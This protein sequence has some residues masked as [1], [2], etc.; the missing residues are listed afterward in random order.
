[1]IS[2]DKERVTISI[3]KDTLKWLDRTAKRMKMNRSEMIEFSLEGSQQELKLLD[4]LGLKPER[5]TKVVHTIKAATEILPDLE[6]V[7][8][9]KGA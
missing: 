2:K 3:N 5:L 6:R 1:M 9:Q 8:Q 4:G 7:I